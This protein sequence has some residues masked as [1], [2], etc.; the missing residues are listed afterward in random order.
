MDLT[1]PLWH[2]ASSMTRRIVS[3]RHCFVLTLKHPASTCVSAKMSGHVFIFCYVMILYIMFFMIIT[4]NIRGGLINV[5]AKTTT[6]AGRN[7]ISLACRGF[8]DLQ[9]T[10]IGYGF[11]STGLLPL[12]VII[13]G[14]WLAKNLDIRHQYALR[15]VIRFSTGL[16]SKLTLSLPIW[17]NVG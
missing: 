4:N 9:K 6:L 11:K 14:R 16:V 15:P 13:V 2:D 10:A 12:L 1:N 3:H 7:N 17:L 5:I 8:Q